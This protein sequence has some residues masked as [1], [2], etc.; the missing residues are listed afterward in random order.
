MKTFRSV[1]LFIFKKLGV[2]ILVVLGLNHVE[3]IEI[4]L[5]D[6]TLSFQHITF[7][8]GIPFQP[9]THILQ[10]EEGYMWFGSEWG[11]CRYNGYEYGSFLDEGITALFEDSHRYLWIGTKAGLIRIDPLRETQVSYHHEPA[12]PQTVNN[13][14]IICMYETRQGVIWVGTRTGLNRFNSQNERW[15][16]FSCNPTIAIPYE[17]PYPSQVNSIQ[18]DKEGRMWIGMETGLFAFDP[19]S[20][21]FTPYPFDFNYSVNSILCSQTGFLWMGNNR[22]LVRF[23]PQI[24]EFKRFTTE[25]P[26]SVLALIQPKITS[27]CEDPTGIL[28]IVSPWAFYRFDPQ[29]ELF[30]YDENQMERPRSLSSSN[31]LSF[32]RERTGAIWVSTDN[33]LNRFDPYESQFRILVPG[34]EN[35]PALSANAVYALC[36]DREEAIWIGTQNGGLNRYDPK[37]NRITYYRHDPTREDTISE[38]TVTAL[39]AAPDGRIWIGSWKQGLCVLDPKNGSVKRYPFLKDEKEIPD[40]KTLNYAIVRSIHVMNNGTIWI[41]TEKGGISILDPETDTFIHFREDTNNL[42][43]NAIR[44]F[45]EDREGTL[46][47]GTGGYQMVAKGLNRFVPEIQSFQH[48]DHLIPEIMDANGIWIHGMAEDRNNQLWLATNYGLFRMNGRTDDYI[49]FTPKNG[50]VDNDIRSVVCAEDGFLWLSTANS[51]LARLDPETQEIVN[52]GELYGL[53]NLQYNI[54]VG[55]KGRD[56][57]LYFGGANGLTILNKGTIERNPNPPPVVIEQIE[58]LNQPVPPSLWKDDFHIKLDYWQNAIIFHFSA[59]SYTNPNRNRYQ[60]RLLGFEQEWFECGSERLVRYASLSPGVYRFQVKGANSDGVWSD[61]K[62]LAIT[63]TPPFWHTGW[64]QFLSLLSGVI[65]ILGFY[66]YRVWKIQRDKRRLEAEVFSRTAQLKVER[67]YLKTIINTSPLMIVG[68]NADGDLT[69]LNPTAEQTFGLHNRDFIGKK[70]WELALQGEDRQKLEALHRQLQERNLIGHELTVTLPS[71]KIRTLIWSFIHH[72]DEY[73]E[74]VETLV[75]VDDIT[76]QI[77]SEILETSRNEQRRIGRE[78]HDSLCQTLTGIT[79]MFGTLSKKKDTM[80]TAQAQMLAEIQEHL[81]AVTTQSRHLSRGLYLHELETHGL[82]DALRELTHSVE[83]IFGVH[84]RL[85]WNGET[86][87]IE[88]H[89]A[90]ELYRIVQEA[91]N[92]AAKHSHSE[93]IDICV[94]CNPDTV[95]TIV[96]DGGTGFHTNSS[97]TKGIGINIMKNRARMIHA[98]LQIN[99]EPGKGTQIV[100][101]LPIHQ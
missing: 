98:F 33:A 10:D 39:A 9:I 72:N 51:G 97:N 53:T 76:E 61:R 17:N 27:M 60:Y 67:D 92:N 95:K 21:S 24:H 77:E 38:D 23:D 88:I 36:E 64:F 80:P 81:Q 14:H 35:P 99:S 55:L 4:E 68:Y 34:K 11:L 101:T 8:D 30:V 87:D 26:N 65:G 16:S 22:G 85:D 70:W 19:L 84:C 62:E 56:G 63:I 86:P 28:W 29:R 66:K 6:N 2:I 96:Q 32:Y 52:Y 58:V 83:T 50:L 79:L 40:A 43:S 15:E 3:A 18:E 13:D 71:G 46:W 37:T 44:S 47:V 49:R 90:T 31:L 57:T 73:G 75:F 91:V 54:G 82:R 12:I 7:R 41:G 93:F 89:T 94:E 74:R 20:G 69:F 78:I 42:S 5:E 1:F 59:L 45:Y 48:Y 100:C 25:K